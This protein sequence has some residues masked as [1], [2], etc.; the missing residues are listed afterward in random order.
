MITLTGIY[1][2]LFFYLS[3]ESG[4]AP[5]L[6]T[7]S[8]TYGKAPRCRGRWSPHVSAASQSP[9]ALGWPC[10]WA[11]TLEHRSEG[12]LVYSHPVTCKTRKKRDESRTHI[13]HAKT[14]NV[15][16]LVKSHSDICSRILKVS[17]YL[18]GLSCWAVCDD[19]TQAFLMTNQLA[20]FYK[21]ILKKRVQFMSLFKWM[22]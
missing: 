8:P 10:W 3:P 12:S 5:S 14:V 4:A 18:P 21:K 7:P 13:E 9:W 19:F 6:D 20:S 17:A 16:G 22:S 15:C 11:C 1:F 2:I